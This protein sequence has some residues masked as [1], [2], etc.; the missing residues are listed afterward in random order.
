MMEKVHYQQRFL[1]K[2]D[3][4]QRSHSF[5]VKIHDMG[6]GPYFSVTGEYGAT[7][8]EEYGQLQHHLNEDNAPDVLL[9]AL[10][11]HLFDVR[12]G[13]MHYV[14]N[15]MYWAGMT[16]PH[17]EYNPEHMK[18][19]ANLGLMDGD[20]ELV[21]MAEEYNN[22]ETYKDLDPVTAEEL[23]EY[24]KEEFENKLE[25]RLDELFRQ[26]DR[27]MEDLFEGYESDWKR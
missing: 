17:T 27:D 25:S 2:V 5:T 23:K 4:Y 20:Q 15:T 1:V 7:D 3:G 8:G 12:S 24:M 9:K 13:P 11:W 14:P 18:S 19:T 21:E 6:S 16:E 22:P 10:R 26:F